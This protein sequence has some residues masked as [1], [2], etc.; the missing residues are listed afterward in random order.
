MTNW[1]V[2]GNQ[3]TKIIPNHSNVWPKGQIKFS[4]GAWCIVEKLF[5]KAITF[6]S[7]DFN[8]NRNKI[9]MS[10]PIVVKP[11]IWQCNPHGELQCNVRRRVVTPP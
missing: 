3:T 1:K 7:K 8:L 2:I 5:L 10:P 11:M 6:S 4:L 9:V